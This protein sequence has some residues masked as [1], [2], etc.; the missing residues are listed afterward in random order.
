MSKTKRDIEKFGIAEFTRRCRESVTRYVEEW[1]RLTERIGFWLD[2][3][4]AYWTMNPEYVQSVWWALKQLHQHDMLF[5]DFKVTAYCPRCGTSL[6][7]HE[8][9][10]GYATVSDP[11][12]YVTFPVTE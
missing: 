6:S 1:E 2:F 10:Q 4:D 9:A 11:S 5:E 8:V 7:D 3:D 12:V